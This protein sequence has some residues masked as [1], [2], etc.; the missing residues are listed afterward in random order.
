MSQSIPPNQIRPPSETRGDVGS[1]KKPLPFQARGQLATAAVLVLLVGGIA[2]YSLQRDTERT[3][4]AYVDGNVVQVT[5][6]IGGTVTAFAADNTDHVKAGTLLVTLNPVDQEVRFERAK[7][8]LAKATRVA[9]TQYSQVQ[10]LRAEV[11]QRKNDVLKTRADLARR[12]TLASSGAVSREEVSHAEDVLKNAEAMLSAV[13][14]S[15]EQRL[16]MVDGTNLRTH[17]DV[18]TAAT[19]LRDAYIAR[20]RTSILSPVDGTVTKRS[21][22][23]GQRINPG[24]ALMSVVPMDELWVNANFKESQLEHLRIGQPAEVTTDVYGRNVVYHGK[25]VGMDAGTGSAFALLPAQNATGNWIKVTQ[26]V[27]IRIA[28]DS[29]EIAKQPLRVGLS[30]RVSVRTTDRSGEMIRKDVAP[31][32]VYK[33]QVYDQEL[34]DADA[35]VEAVIRANE[36]QTP[37]AEK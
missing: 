16:A 8:E 15:L 26:R 18:L 7:A 11:V 14:Q 12:S 32:F 30:M 4:D 10:Q 31:N 37:M 9:R 21:V 29:K 34:R 5:S 19:N 17:P 28:L 1:E 36:G 33:T 25:I 27:P 20:S 24:V 35:I 3:E 2:W 23:L 13:N 22:Q 6:Q